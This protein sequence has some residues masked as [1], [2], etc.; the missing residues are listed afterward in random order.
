[1][2]KA[3]VERIIKEAIEADYHTMRLDTHPWMKDAERLYRS[4]GFKET[5]AYN[6]NPTKGIKFFELHL[7]VT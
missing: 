1:M 7:K 3:L 5:E 2:G 4:F 6:D